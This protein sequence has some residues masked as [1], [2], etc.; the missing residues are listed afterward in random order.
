MRKRP[1][2]NVRLAEDDALFLLLYVPE[3][4]L[5]LIGGENFVTIAGAYLIIL[6]CV[7][8]ALLVGR[9]WKRHGRYS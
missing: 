9:H 1:S 4:V 6:V 7:V 2:P 5:V 8:N 3:V